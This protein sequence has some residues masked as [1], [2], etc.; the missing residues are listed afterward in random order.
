MRITLSTCAFDIDDRFDGVRTSFE[1]GS[2]WVQPIQR[3]VQPPIFNFALSERIDFVS[4]FEPKAGFNDDYEGRVRSYF[5]SKR[6]DVADFVDGQRVL[7]GRPA[8][9][10]TLSYLRDVGA[11]TPVENFALFVNIPLDAEFV[12]EFSADCALADRDTYEPLFWAA[13]ESYVY[14]GGAREAI[15]AQEAAHAE[16]M[17]AIDDLLSRLGALGNSEASTDEDAEFTALAGFTVPHDGG[18]HA[19]VAGMRLDQVVARCV[20]PESSRALSVRVSMRFPD[21][22]SALE[23]GVL[24]EYANA[25]RV[26]MAVSV[27]G[28]YHGSGMPRGRFAIRDG[29][30]PAYNS[31]VRVTDLAYGCEFNGLLEFIDGWMSLRGAIYRSY[32]RQT[33]FDVDVCVPLDAAAIEWAEYEFTSIEEIASAPPEQVRH[34]QLT[35]LE[36]GDDLSLLERC[37]E[38]RTLFLRHRA[39]GT[40][41]AVRVPESIFGMANLT[42]LTIHSIALPRVPDALGR[43]TSLVRLALTRCDLTETPDALW[44]LP[45]LRWL[46][47]D[48]N[49]IERL[50]PQIALPALTSIN[51]SN[52]ALRL[53]PDSLF[54]LPNLESLDLDGNPWEALPEAA[55]ADRF[56]IA[57]D[58]ASKRRLLDFTYRGRDGA[59]DVIW[60]EDS[61][62]ARSSA[63][64]AAVVDEVLAASPQATA[65]ADALRFLAKRGVAIRLGDAEDY[66]QLGNHRVGG[67]P[68]LPPSMPYPR[69]DCDGASKPYEF[70]CQLDCAD[71]ARFQD[72]LPRSGFLYFFLSTLHDL[73]GN[74][75]RAPR[76]LWFDGPREALASGRALRI[77][78][79]EY[80]EMSG[81]AYEARRA[82]AGPLVSAPHWYAV[83]S[84]PHLL[85]GPAA[86]L[87]A[88]EHFLEAMA[89]DHFTAPLEARFPFDVAVGGYGFTQH[90]DPEHQAALVR[91][92]NPEDWVIL[93]QVKSILDMQW[94][95]A[96]ELFFVAHK[97]DLAAHDFSRVFCT[98]ESS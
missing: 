84:N 4:S 5:D 75:A 59:T 30:G 42:E 14:T 53:L 41:Q 90:E 45:S 92:G 95:D 73:Y 91:K 11:D 44:T 23:S 74:D 63:A 20:V 49:R 64:L 31:S 71:L 81:D 26:E 6:P 54:A 72:Y 36:E 7:A 2:V 28:V 17:A 9:F 94:G 21:P 46:L 60:N 68:D 1:S 61:Y 51:L 35:S 32:D 27:L 88:D 16:Q 40:P 69:F 25:G 15:N 83:R 22:V 70:L 24:S 62:H 19:R 55:N 80:F 10:R 65:H 8:L 66:A 56:A 43:S 38:L 3:G 34:V 86:T 85:R 67:M 47:L 93:L 77:D 57:L 98:M 97:R 96:G 78:A 58:I 87:A 33:R 79:S 52:N 29:K 39:W 37:T 76:V 82:V 89:H 18:E 13:I 12:Q 48:G 50:P